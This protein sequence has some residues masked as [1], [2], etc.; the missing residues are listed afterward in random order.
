MGEVDDG[1]K[2]VHELLAQRASRSPPAPVR[3]KLLSPARPRLELKVDLRVLAV[4][5]LPRV[6][7]VLE[8][9]GGQHRRADTVC[10]LSVG[11]GRGG[12]KVG[13]E[14]MFFFFGLGR[15]PP[16]AP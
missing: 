15:P 2:L 6:T 14:K 12:G 3:R 7:R 9:V 5:V 4:G 1:R 8:Q 16:T 13:N 11:W 10:A